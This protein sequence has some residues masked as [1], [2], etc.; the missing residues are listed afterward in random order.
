MHVWNHMDTSLGAAKEFLEISSEQRL[1][2]ILK[3][4]EKKSKVS[5]IA[6]ELEV[7]VPGGL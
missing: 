1:R 4:S 3:L 6:K 5:T 2:I 7:T